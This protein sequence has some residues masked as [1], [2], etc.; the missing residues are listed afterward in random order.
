MGDETTNLA[1]VLSEERLLHLLRSTEHD[2]VERKPK[3]QYG[4]WLQTAVAF[5][6]SAPQGFPAVLFVGVDNSGTPQEQDDAPGK[7][8][9]ERL[10]SLQKSITDTLDKAYPPIYRL[11]LPLRVDGGGCVAVIIPG[12]KNRPHF[13]RKAYVRKGPSTT[14]AS[15]DQFNSLIAE[16]SAKVYDLRRLIGK[17]AILE[18]HLKSHTSVHREVV[19]IVECNQH[20]L[21]FEK[22]DSRKRESVPVDRLALAYNYGQ[23]MPILQTWA[24]GA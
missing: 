21:T 11:C 1:E 4:D 9:Q 6:N 10:E 22:V 14:E 23:D 13:A 20:Y 8:L 2:F 15:E 18:T 19:G 24:P 5:A 17:R 3:G 12:S 7:P 16:R